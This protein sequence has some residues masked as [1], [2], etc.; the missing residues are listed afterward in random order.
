MYL[1]VG[2][3]E[4]SCLYFY[5][6]FSR[7]WLWDRCA[8][9]VE[10]AVFRFKEKSFLSQRGHVRDSNSEFVWQGKVRLPYLY[11]FR[12]YKNS[13]VC[14]VK[15]F[16]GHS[17]SNSAFI[18]HMLNKRVPLRVTSRCIT[19]VIADIICMITCNYVAI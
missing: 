16:L 14:L 12:D 7:T 15:R 9:H 3:V 10:V 5:Q 8:A 18:K 19:L 4:C 13:P 1:P 17:G 6:D 2:G 11:A